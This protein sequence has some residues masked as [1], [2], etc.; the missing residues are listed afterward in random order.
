MEHELINPTPNELKPSSG[1]PKS[2]SF[3]LIGY[4][5]LLASLLLYAACEYFNLTTDQFMIFWIHYFI[6]I[7]YTGVL[8]GGGYYGIRKSWKKENLDKTIVALNLYLISAYALNR[9]IQVFENSVPWLCYFIVIT[10]AT[11]LSFRYFDKLPRWINGLQYLI[12]GSALCF[13]IYLSIYAASYYFVGFVGI[14]ALGIGIHIFVPVTLVTASVFLFLQNRTSTGLWYWSLSGALATLAIV[15]FFVVEWNSRVTRIERIANQSV[16][17]Q[18]MELPVWVNVAQGMEDD[19]I[20]ERILK[21][22]LVYTVA[23]TNMNDWR[24]MPRTVSWDEI[25]RHDPLVFIASLFSTS[26]LSGEERVNIYKALSGNRHNANERLWSG[27]NLSTAYVV[28][29]VDIYPELRLAYTE[30]YLNIKNNSAHG[31]WWGNTE[32]AIYTF[33]LPEGS[34]VTSLSLWINGKE[35]KGILTSKQ[36]ATKAYNTIVGVEVRDPSV[37][38][39]QE[40]NTVTVRVFPC[41]R[42]EERKFKIGI[43]SPLYETNGRIVYQDILFNGPSAVH[44]KET[45]RIRFIGTPADVALPEY[46]SRDK[47]GDY[48]AELPYNP[49]FNLSFKAVPIKNNQ[50]TFDGYTYSLNDYNPEL[51]PLQLKHIY[52]DVNQSWTQEETDALKVLT[53]QYTIYTFVDEERISVRLDTWDDILNSA[54]QQNFSIFPFH[55]MEDPEHALVITKGKTMSP[56][57]IDFKDS[58]FAT[59]VRDFFVAGKRVNVFNLKGGSSTYINSFRELRGLNF[60]TGT[61]A[62]L[63]EMLHQHSFVVNVE[64]DE[65]IIL[66]DASMLITKTKT[67]DTT[68]V[69]NAP[70]HLARLFAYNNIMRKVGA[71]YFANDYIDEALV[72]EAATAYVVSPVSS[73]IVLETQEDYKR[74]DIQDKENSLHN[75]TKN[76]TGA[77]PEPHEWALIILLGLFIFY[78]KFRSAFKFKLG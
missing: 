9:E 70:D 42:A 30:K 60:A 49:D 3:I 66:H 45:K 13:Y 46:F 63:L 26:S 68:V 44:A 8:I 25:Q 57:L 64:S 78:L 56:H 16:M 7:V 48:L 6:S 23:A 72:D 33:Y 17:Y 39:W 51:K 77:V 4:G 28:S 53:E 21:S 76:S 19:W 47:K 59:G 34:V 65:Q 50:F 10:S 58:K 52:L 2:D 41:T 40:G 22:N 62:E 29:D 11:L 12:L 69:N 27:D 32:E 43:T 38:H 14:L 71:R 18:Q 37:I 31:S 74:F 36:K 24:F 67:T 73:L 61:P 1:K 20:S 75:A 15:V 54:R 5:L 35:E 55:R